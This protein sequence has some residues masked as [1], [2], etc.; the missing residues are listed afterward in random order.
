MDDAKKQ[1]HTQVIAPHETV[2]ERAAAE[3]AAADWA[4]AFSDDSNL[5]EKNTE[6]KVAVG[7]LANSTVKAVKAYLGD[8]PDL[9]GLVD[10]LKAQVMSMSW[11]S[12]DSSERKAAVKYNEVTGRYALLLI[13]RQSSAKDVEASLFGAKTYTAKI[14]FKFKRAQAKNDEARKKCQTL[15]NQQVG[16]LV[17]QIELMNVF[18]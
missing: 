7:A 4:N 16:D 1:G 12:K 5:E 17:K 15:V 18:G 9:L 14:H 13:E 6:L 8:F 2:A 11:S 10:I 3:W